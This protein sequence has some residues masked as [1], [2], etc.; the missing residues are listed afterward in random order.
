MLF[1][2]RLP[3]AEIAH[4]DPMFH[5]LRLARAFVPGP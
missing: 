3:R 2:G 4:A 1:W 5:K